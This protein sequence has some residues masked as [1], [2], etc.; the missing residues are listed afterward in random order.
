M[1]K[2]A[3]GSVWGIEVGER[4]NNQPW[5][6]LESIKTNVIKYGKQ[7]N[8]QVMAVMVLRVK[9]SLPTVLLNKVLLEHNHAHL[10]MYYLWLLLCYNLQWQ[11]WGGAT[12]LQWLQTENT[13]YW[14][15]YRKSLRLNR[16]NNST[17]K[18]EIRGLVHL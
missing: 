11:S 10:L 3:L 6:V 17:L 16:K 8:Y 13:H 5:L 1:E 9:I 15:L 7:I 2:Q 18:Y 4:G 12:G 14:A